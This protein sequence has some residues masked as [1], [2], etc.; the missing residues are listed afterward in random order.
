MDVSQF[1]FRL[2]FLF[3]PGI[4]SH[5]IL[6]AFTFHRKR[7]VHLV[8]LRS[9]VLGILSYFVLYQIKRV[10]A[11]LLL[12]LWGI[13]YNFTVKIFDAFPGEKPWISYN[14]IFWTTILA[15]PL[16]LCIAFVQN[17][18]YHYHIA[19]KLRITRRIG[20]LDLWNY[21]FEPP[22]TGWVVVRDIKNNLAYQGWIQGFSE[23]SRENEL[24]LREVIVSQNDSGKELYRVDALYLSRDPNDLTI[25]F[26]LQKKDESEKSKEGD[27]NE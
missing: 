25:E 4:I 13:Q 6:E 17:K 7:E 16:S 10:Y 12:S 21:T 24:L 14:E 2:L 27:S 22:D 15:V 23:T 9:F 20:D 18:K 3:F 8:I 1:T 26:I 11:F 19:K 5:F